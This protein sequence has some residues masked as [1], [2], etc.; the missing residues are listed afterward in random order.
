MAT[1]HAEQP[2]V[3]PREEGSA[4]LGTSRQYDEYRVKL[5]KVA[6]REARERRE[7]LRLEWEARARE[8]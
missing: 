7:Q 6:C 8:D 2:R 3:P 5:Y 4:R 1:L